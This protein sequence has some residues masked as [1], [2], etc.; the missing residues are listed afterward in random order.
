MFDIL[1]ICKHCGTHLNADE[2]DVGVTLPCPECAQDITIPVGDILFECARCG[3]SL[4]AGRTAAR[5]NFHCPSCGRVITIPALGKQHIV[6]ETLTSAPFPPPLSPLS[7]LPPPRAAPAPAPTPPSGSP[8]AA[9]QQ[10]M[11][12]WGDYLAEAGLADDKPAQ[13]PQ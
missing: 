8:A 11:A 7:P 3:K 6:S 5:Q 10:F 1:F 13:P 2:N 9:D 12:T 4:L